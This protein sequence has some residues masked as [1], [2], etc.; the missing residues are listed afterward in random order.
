M[1]LPLIAAGVVAR[2]AAKKLAT[3]AAKKSATKTVKATAQKS[4]TNQIAKNS[5]KVKE[6]DNIKR[7]RSNVDSYYKTVKAKSGAT[8]RE[9]AADVV[10]RVGRATKKPT[11]KI[12]S[13]MKSTKAVKKTSPKKK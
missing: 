4:K 13:S 12:D 6:A 10:E 9:K 11:I 1:A 5:V 7:L 2:A 3:K 8:A